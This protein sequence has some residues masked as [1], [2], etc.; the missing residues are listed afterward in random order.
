MARTILLVHGKGEVREELAAY[1]RNAGL[2]VKTARD[3]RSAIRRLS[4]EPFDLVVCELRLS[5]AKSL[6]LL[7]Y[8]RTAHAE[9]PLIFLPDGF[10]ATSSSRLHVGRDQN[11]LEFLMANWRTS[12]N[13]ASG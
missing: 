13:L 4:E 3:L 1:L 10:D 12:R 9:L 2:K 5:N 6:E 8:V 7:K 11:A